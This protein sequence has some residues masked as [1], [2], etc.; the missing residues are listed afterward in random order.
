MCNKYAV[1]YGKGL[2]KVNCMKSGLSDFPHTT[3]NGEWLTHKNGHWTG[4]FWVGLLWF[5]ALQTRTDGDFQTAGDWAMRFKTR[6]ADNKTHDQGFIYGPSCVMGFN[7]LKS[8]TFIPLIHAGSRNMADLFDDNVELVLAWDEP[9]YERT[10]IVDTIMNLPLMWV[11]DSLKGDNSHKEIMARAAK[12]II[13][14]HVR[15]DFSTSHV[16]RWDNRLNIVQDTHQ[17]ASPDSCWSRGQAW[18]LYGFANMYRYTEDSTYLDIATKLAE[19]FYHNLNDDKLPAW[20][21]VYKGNVAHPIDAAAASIAASGMLLISRLQGSRNKPGECIYWESCAKEILDVLIE[22]C[23]C[24]DRARY[25]IL[26]GVTVDYPRK[27]GLGESSM[28][29]DYYFM[30]ALYRLQYKEK[31]DQYLY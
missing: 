24:T 27:S 16:V 2:G 5:N 29:G 30:E 26:K 18:A 19:Y 20:D 17:G 23:M 15:S 13:K 10:A 3:R 25:G 28:Y 7:I 4:G 21:F 1:A 31:T 6:M 14:Y 22:Q 11:S 9:G 8:E 12:S